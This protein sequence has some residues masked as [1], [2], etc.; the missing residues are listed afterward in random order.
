MSLK[1]L[2]EGRMIFVLRPSFIGRL[3][4]MLVRSDQVKNVKIWM[5][6]SRNV[7][8]AEIKLIASVV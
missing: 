4:V 3:P 8:I 7:P 5:K 2:T 1:G 6:D